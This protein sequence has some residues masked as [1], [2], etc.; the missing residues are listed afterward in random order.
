MPI[1]E[2]ELRQAL[3]ARFPN[4]EITLTDTAGDDDHWHARIVSTEF[5]GKSRVMQHKMVQEA[6]KSYNI[7]ALSIETKPS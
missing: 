1:T 6:V 4:S 2:S 7:H 5:E 3:E